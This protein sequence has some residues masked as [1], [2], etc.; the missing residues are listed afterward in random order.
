MPVETEEVAAAAPPPAVPHPQRRPRVREVSSRFMSPVS[1]SHSSGDHSRSPLHKQHHLQRQRRQ[2]EPE[3]D[4]NIPA[5]APCDTPRASLES[6]FINITTVQKKH[7][8][9]R[10]Y[11]DTS[12]LFGR[13]TA[14]N[15]PLRPDTPTIERTSS[16][17]SSTIRLNHRTANV[18]D[19]KG[20]G[21]RQVSGRTALSLID[22]GTSLPEADNNGDGAEPSLKLSRSLNSP[23]LS[24]DPSLFHL[25]NGLMKGKSAKVTPFSL[26]PVPSHTKHGT[27]TIRGSKKISRHQEDLHSLKLLYNCYLQWRF[28]NAKAENS[29][30]IQKRETERI[31]YSLEVKISELYDRVRRKRMEL[32]LLQRMKTLSNILESHMPYL[33]EWS[34][35]QGDYLNSLSEAIQSL[36]NISLRLPINGNVKVD[37]REV[38]EAMT[39]AIKMMEMIVSNVQSFMPKAEEMESSVSE[40]AR[41]AIGERAVIEEC[42]DL[43]YKTNTFQVEECSLRAQLIQL[44]AMGSC[45]NKLLLQE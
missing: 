30:Q 33:E 42:G 4:E 6:P 37:T 35:F 40:L 12:K 9:S 32:Q 17:P 13:S 34:T 7:R 29:T 22:L 23:L 38:G 1:S 45:N 39:S 21:G 31:L 2:S 8:H 26:P 44:Q 14:N 10:T 36:L 18:G 25:P 19:G 5:V 11:S 15:T 27:D 24:S 16:L 41:V 43:L 28:A 20:I 3:V